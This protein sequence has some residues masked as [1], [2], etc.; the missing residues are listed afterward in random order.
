MVT[1][2]MTFFFLGD[3]TRCVRPSH[4]GRHREGGPGAELLIGSQLS[5]PAGAGRPDALR[6]RTRLRGD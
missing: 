4:G 5:R 2:A 3:A 6:D 1:T